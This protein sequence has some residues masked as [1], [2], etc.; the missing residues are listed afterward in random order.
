MPMKIFRYPSPLAE[1]RVARIINRGLAFPKK[2]MAAVNRICEDVRKRGDQAVISYTR[3]FDSARLTVRSM[4]VS[5]KEFSDAARK[6][7]RSF[8]RALKR[9]ASNIRRFHE[10]QLRRSWT[11]CQAKVQ[12]P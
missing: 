6:V 8:K 2:D 7:D 5:Q 4:E 12:P 1:Q 10:Q 11:I 3:R 9:A